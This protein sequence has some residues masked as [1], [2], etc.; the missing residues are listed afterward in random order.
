M[1]KKKIDHIAAAI[2]RGAEIKFK[3]ADDCERSL[4]LAIDSGFNSDILY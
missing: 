1:E 4:R 2:E 3:L